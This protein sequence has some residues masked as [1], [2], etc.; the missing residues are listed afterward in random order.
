[1]SIDLTNALAGTGLTPQASDRTEP[2][3]QEVRRLAEQFEAML[4]T[5]MLREMRRSMLD[6][7]ENEQNGLGAGPLTDIGNVEFGSALSR[8]GGLGVTDSLLQA[9][10][11]AVSGRTGQARQ[12]GLA[13]QAGQAAEAALTGQTGHTD[14]FEVRGDQT[15]P[16]AVPTVL[17][18]TGGSPISSRFGWRTDPIS[19][20][21]KFHKGIDIAVAYGHEVTA[22]ANGRVSF[23][24]VQGGYGQTVIVDHADGRQ[25]RYA[26]LS[27][28]F[29]K[30]G[31]QVAAGQVVAKSGTRAA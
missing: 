18:S 26:H 10:E 13:G 11:R 31:D 3:R 8:N 14:L 6:E 20:E 15:L 25:T 29:V 24:G 21:S 19:G 27:E 2:E 4:L 17:P 1:M 9:F 22:V 12:A 16:A 30:V 23:A 5:Q 7:D 28:Q